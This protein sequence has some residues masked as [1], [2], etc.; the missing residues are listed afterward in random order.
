MGCLA[1]VRRCHG[2]SVFLFLAFP[3]LSN[4]QSCRSHWYLLGCSFLSEKIFYSYLQRMMLR[5]SF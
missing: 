1:A 3:G 4:L 5:V 2:L